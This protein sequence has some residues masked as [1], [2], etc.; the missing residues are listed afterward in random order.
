MNILGIV[1]LA[2]IGLMILSSKVRTQE[3]IKFPTNSPSKP[4]KPSIKPTSTND[5]QINNVDTSL[6]NFELGIVDQPLDINEAPPLNGNDNM[7]IINGFTLPPINQYNISA[8]FS[9]YEF[10]SKD[11]SGRVP[12]PEN[13]KPNVKFLC[14]CLLERIRQHYNK[15]VIIL[16][17]YR[18]QYHNQEVHG[19]VHSQHLLGK[20]ADIKISGISPGNLEAWLKSQI[21]ILTCL[22]GLGH[23]NN[24]T[25]VDIRPRNSNG[26]I[27]EWWG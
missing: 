16:S 7:P 5:T 1:A 12:V 15:P 23:Y 14:D 3:I 19:V 2:I 18:T 21:S 10:E 25:H 26:T 13:L 4:P 20:A 24:F 8:N 6:D 17:G 11:S 9:W 27:T 22:G